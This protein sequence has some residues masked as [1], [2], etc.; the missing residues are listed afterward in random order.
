MRRPP[1]RPPLTQEDEALWR[2]IQETAR[3]LETR[4]APMP[5]DAQNLTPLPT[6]R[7]VPVIPVRPV[8]RELGPLQVGQTHALGPAMTKKIKRGELPVDRRIDLH[9]FTLAAAHSYLQRQCADAITRGER[10]LL[11]IT[12]RGTSERPGKLRYA[13][14]TPLLRRA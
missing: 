10:V 9:G 2:S 12:G 5:G 7:P 13:V 3:P 6:A 14:R 4:R 11:I 8:P 1:S